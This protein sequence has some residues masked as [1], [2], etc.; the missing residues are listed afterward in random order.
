MATARSSAV[1]CIATLS[2]AKLVFS[3][4]SRGVLFNRGFLGIDHCVGRPQLD[5]GFTRDADASGFSIDR[6]QQVD[7]EVDVDVGSHGRGD[8]PST[9]PGRA[10]YRQRHHRLA[11]NRSN[12][13]A[14]IMGGS[15][16]RR[17]RVKVVRLSAVARAADRDE[18]DRFF[19]AICHGHKVCVI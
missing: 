1:A 16:L 2:S 5:E 18:A 15:A 9:G 19:M 12:S 11:A 17:L 6:A 10:S 3:H 4:R 13:L 8:E 7:G 14:V